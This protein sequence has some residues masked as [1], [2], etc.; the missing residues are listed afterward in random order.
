MDYFTHVN[1][2][3]DGGYSHRMVALKKRNERK[4]PPKIKW[5]PC[6][7]CVHASTTRKDSRIHFREVHGFKCMEG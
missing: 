7:R 4:V 3:L 2:N 1:T 5:Y 6:S